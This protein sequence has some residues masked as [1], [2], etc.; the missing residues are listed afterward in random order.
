MVF[1]FFIKVSEQ[2]LIKRFKIS[3]M[4]KTKKPGDWHN[5]KGWEKYY[6]SLIRKDSYL[7]EA[8]DTGSISFDRL[9]QFVDELK[10]NNITNV[11]VAGCGLSL[12]PKLLTKGGLNVHATDIS[13]SAIA[14]QRNNDDPK[15][16][17]LIQKSEIPASESGLLTAEVHDFSQPYLGNYFDFVINVKAIQG[18]DRDTMRQIAKVH[19]D[20]LKPSRQ[21]I[22]DTMNVQ[23]ERREMLEE[24]IVDAGFFLPFY[25]LNVWYRAKLSDTGIPHVFILGQPMIPR[26]GEYAND[27][28][29][30]QHDIQILRAIAAEFREKQQAEAEMVKKHF[31]KHPET[32]TANIIY[33]TG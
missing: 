18:F 12:M 17:D 4:F 25:E 11:W 16:W 14:F 30:W 33:S 32:K 8:R 28:T 1:D 31:V 7:D 6:A 10:S 20:A 15:V 19:Y 27:E 3:F 26:I 24:S 21:A 13:P 2:I 29:K 22:F 23:G 5:Q 9:P